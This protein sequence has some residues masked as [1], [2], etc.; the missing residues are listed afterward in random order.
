M[1]GG[2]VRVWVVEVVGGLLEVGRGFESAWLRW[3]V[4]FLFL[5]SLEPRCFASV[6]DRGGMEYRVGDFAFG[7]RYWTNIHLISRQALTSTGTGE[8]DYACRIVV[9]N[10][11]AYRRSF[12]YVTYS[13]F[14]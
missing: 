6:E 14:L 13:R 8:H 9:L 2:W 5:V 10:R 11:L 7:Y 12:D 3:W 1:Q 4:G